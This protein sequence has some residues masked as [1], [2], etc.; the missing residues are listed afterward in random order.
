MLNPSPRT[1][2]KSNL[3]YHALETR[4]MLAGVVSV[5]LISNNLFIRGDNDSNE[6]SLSLDSNNIATIEGSADT[7]IEFSKNKETRINLTS[8][9]N[10]FVHMGAGDDL[11]AFDMQ[12]QGIAGNISIQLANGNDT[13]FLMGDPETANAIGGDLR[14]HCSSGSDLVFVSDM[15]IDD[16]LCV[17]GGR[18]DDLVMLQSINVHDKTLISSQAGDD[19]IAIADSE[20]G[21]KTKIAMGIHNDHFESV[22]SKFKKRFKLNSSAGIDS[23][24]ISDT[25]EL[26]SSE[27]IRSVEQRDLS[28]AKDIIDSLRDSFD[29]NLGSMNSALTGKT[30]NAATEFGRQ[31]GINFIELNL[32]PQSQTVQ[33]ADPTPSLS[34]RWDQVTQQAVAETDLG[35]T[36]ASRA[37]GMVHTAIYDAWSAYDEPAISTQLDDQLQRPANQI[38]DENKSEAMSFAAFRILNDLFATQTDSFR[39]LMNNLGYDS[40]DQSRNPETPAGVG[41]LM[42][43]AILAFRHADGSN[44]TGNDAN[45][46]GQPYSDTTGYV[47]PNPVGTAVDIEKWTPE[48]VPIDSTP[49]TAV[50]VQKFLTPQWSAVTPFALSSP[51]QFRT[52]P[53]QP[54][55]LVDGTT[56]L[57]NATI[58]LSNGTELDINKTLIGTVINPVFISQAE[59]LIETSSNLT[60][61]QK[62]ISEFWEDANGTAF[63]PG[64]WQTFGQYV[65]ARD[66]HSLDQDAQMFLA[67]ANSIF[68]AGIATWDAKV[69]YDYVR[70]VRAIRELGQLGL[71]GE[72]DE[73]LN[74]FA[75]DAWTP[76][77][78]TQRIL[79]TNFLTYQTPGGHPSPPFSEYPSGHSSFS[80]AGAAILE[81]FSGSNDFGASVSFEPGESRFEPGTTPNQRVTLTWDTFTS[82]AR[83]AGVSRR[84]GGIH[85][86]DG[87]LNGERLGQQVAEVT[88]Q[89]TQDLISGNT[90]S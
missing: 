88:W 77:G 27:K 65:S 59:T 13:L 43:D 8:L 15:S 1:R 67:L 49:D 83:E 85:F 44:Q 72:F 37:F 9:D 76:E 26:L 39:S 58:T 3:N 41:N 11:V 19:S 18:G 5:D 82:A 42:A 7:R 22:S 23:S 30:Q 86:T 31:L 69:H 51:D 63:P 36:V 17:T 16:D 10:V 35:P 40:T 4:Q 25:N 54:F 47:P 52:D 45:G 21:G 33:V 60:D 61:D 64:T 6:I 71:I 68:D 84:Y 87:D 28:K 62:L 20:F 14:I 90:A 70:P 73:Q 79:A 80:A 50:K 2:Q 38:T 66:N 34:A 56:D 24:S 29:Q 57:E 46:N 32:D 74:G 48:R 53:P 78:F 55:L 12:S 89:R 75:I 81:R